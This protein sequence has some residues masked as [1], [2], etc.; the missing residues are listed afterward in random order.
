MLYN[1]KEHALGLVRH[2]PYVLVSVERDAGFFVNNE[3]AQDNEL[4][5]ITIKNACL[6]ALLLGSI[7]P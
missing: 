3:D 2:V 7:K 4:F 5:H 6:V 1:S